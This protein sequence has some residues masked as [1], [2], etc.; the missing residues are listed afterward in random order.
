MD[1][2]NSFHAQP[3]VN[4]GSPYQNGKVEMPRIPPEILDSP[5]M[6]RGGFEVF[7][8]I[9]DEF[10]KN[11]LLSE[12]VSQKELIENKVI[13][14][15]TEEIRGGAPQRRF[16]NGA[17][18]DFQQS[19]YRA[20]WLLDFL[21]GLTTPALY[22]TGGNGTYSFYLRSG[23]FLDI[24]RDIVACDVAVI[25]CLKNQSTVSGDGG[26]LCL[27]PDRINEPLSSIRTT[28]DKGTVKL[29]LEEGQT[30]VMYGGLVPHAL[31]PIT[32]GQMRIVSVLCYCAL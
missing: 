26:K 12:A 21:R 10:I 16:L 5:L 20:D 23:D 15:D 27:Y 1:A 17:G 13:D 3:K 22:P 11:S 25:T 4:A 18:G 32:T 6:Q 9:A 28:P 7:T 31:L 2:A 19:F 30:I 24:H 14:R 29:G 8:G